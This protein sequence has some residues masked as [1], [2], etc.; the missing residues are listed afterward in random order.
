VKPVS[1]VRRTRRVQQR[2]ALHRKRAVARTQP[3]TQTRIAVSVTC[4][5][6]Y[7]NLLP[8]QL[9]AIDAQVYPPAEK[10]LVLDDCTYDAPP[11][12]VVLSHN[13]GTPNLGRN[14]AVARTTCAWIIFADADDCMH[15]SYTLG[16]AEALKT[17]PDGTGIVYADIDYTKGLRVETPSRF[18]YWALRRKN[19][20]SACA[21]WATAAITE[22]GGW[23]KNTPCHDD[24]SLALN[25]TRLGW[26]AVKNAVCIQTRPHS[27]IPHR[28][29]ST[30]RSQGGG[31]L[32][33]HC[34]YGI[35]SLLGGRNKA[36][37][38]W[39]D[40][41]SQEELPPRVTFYAV[42][43]FNDPE[44]REEIQA[45]LW[46][47]NID[48][49]W[50]THAQACV[51]KQSSYHRGVHVAHLYN[52]V[53]PRVHEDMLLMLEDDVIPPRGGVRKLIDAW[54]TG[55]QMGGIGGVYTSRRGYD[56]AVAASHSTYWTKA[57]HIKDL[58]E[59]KLYPFTQ[60]AGGFTLW[61]NGY[62]QECLP[63]RYDYTRSGKFPRGWDTNLSLAV[64]AMGGK[65]FLHGGLQCEHR[66]S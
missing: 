19:Y 52:R 9:A 24:Y 3:N 23:P 31:R 36:T 53:L 51:D 63:C 66:F 2:R 50:I 55:K 60:I 4:H 5:K 62:V 42:D 21:G 8:A 57:P 6:P 61:N 59:D 34:S 54:G 18:N 11:G 39:L 13:A 16:V 65:L 49:V 28:N 44:F 33:N 27:K 32:W 25:I 41:V 26:G 46:D 12:W 29:T 20:I 30:A 64:T 37:S 17:A 45:A 48:T 7:L 35:V 1:A 14:M 43:N 22:A 47:N 56:K 10:F 40:W 58:Q 38:D 15:P